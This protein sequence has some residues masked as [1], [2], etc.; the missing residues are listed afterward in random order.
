M[1]AYEAEIGTRV[2][3]LVAFCDVPAGTQ[4]VIDE[5]YDGGVMV[6]WDRPGNPLP[7]GYT[8]FAGKMAFGGP[9][10]DGFGKDELHYLKK[11]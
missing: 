7:K 8:R 2:R 10:R 11:L 1:E 5:I 6:A 3:S 4:G 9:L